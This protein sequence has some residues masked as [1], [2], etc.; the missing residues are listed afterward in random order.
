[1]RR[2]FTSCRMVSGYSGGRADQ[3]YEAVAT[4]NRDLSAVKERSRKVAL[5]R[6]PRGIANDRRWEAG[7][8]NHKDMNTPL[9]AI[10]R[11]RRAA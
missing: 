10:S 4:K 8:P 3:N 6:L 5:R 11:T 1:V 9:L 7:L 2:G